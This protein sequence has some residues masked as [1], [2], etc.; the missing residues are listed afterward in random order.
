MGTPKAVLL[1]LT[2]LLCSCSTLKEPVLNDQRIE[3]TSENLAAMNG[4]YRR[5][6]VS[7]T[8]SD[9]HYC[10]NNLFHSLFLYP[11]RYLWDTKNEGDLVE[12]EVIDA[13]KIKVTLWVDG[14]I[15]KEKILKGKIASN[16]FEFNR[17]SLL[18][19]LLFMNYYEDRKTRI[20]V[21]QN[22]NLSMDT[23]TGAVGNFLIIPWA[24]G[25][26]SAENSEFEK[27]R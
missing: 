25:H 10:P 11:G 2:G 13:K 7:D 8:I 16:T 12:L 1:L 6:A 17:R 21:L 19:P 26:Y 24:S 23:A 9:R 5:S 20:S 22:G 15:D 27:V 4:I 18:V 14:K 3:M